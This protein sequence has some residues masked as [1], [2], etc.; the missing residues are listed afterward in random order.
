MYIRW[1]VEE[2]LMRVWEMENG[3]NATTIKS[4]TITVVKYKLE[5]PAAFCK[6]QM[7]IRIEKAR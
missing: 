1:Y 5:F 2:K 3:A 4:S 7:K 6:H